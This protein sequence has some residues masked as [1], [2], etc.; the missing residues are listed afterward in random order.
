MK[1]TAVLITALI[2]LLV[3][4]GYFLY[5]FWYK[6]PPIDIWQAIPSSAIMV[7]ENSNVVKTWNELQVKPVW[8]S[9]Q[10]IPYYQQL[11]LNIANLDSIPGE[12]GAL[13]RVLRDQ[14]FLCSLHMISKEAFDFLFYVKV[15][16]LR[17]QE[18]LSQIEDHYRS[19]NKFQFLQRNYQ[20]FTINEFKKRGEDQFFSYIIH[21]NYFMASFSPFLVEGV[22]RNL[23]DKR[24]TSFKDLNPAL[25]RLKK[26]EN[27][28]GNLYVN[29][30]QLPQFFSVFSP[31]KDRIDLEPLKHLAQSILFDLEVNEEGLRC[32]GF[33]LTESVKGQ[34]LESFLGQKPQEMRLKRLLSNRTALLYHFSYQEPE[35]WLEV[36][37]NYWKTNQPNQIQNKATLQENYGFQTD[38]LGSWLGNELG[39]AVLESINPSQPDRLIY[40]K[41]ADPNQALNQFNRLAEESAALS[42]DSLYKEPYAGL[43]IREIK[44]TEFPAKLLGGLFSGFGQC[45]VMLFDDYIILGSNIQTLKNL[46]RDI[47]REDVWSKSP[48]KNTFFESTLKE[49]NLSVIVDMNRFWSL[50]EVQTTPKWMGFMQSYRTQLKRFDLAAL[51]FSDV[52]DKFYTNLVLNHQNLS[53]ATKPSN[54]YQFVQKVPVQTP[55]IT[56][57]FVVRNHANNAREV[58]VQDQ[59]HF[60]YLIS[61]EGRLLWRDSLPGPIRGKVNQIDYFKNGKLQYLLATDRDLHL[62]DRTGQQVSGFPVTVPTEA[63]LRNV[64]PIDYDNSKNYRLIAS[65][66][67]GNIYLFDKEGGLLEGW[68]PRTLKYQLVSAPVHL[69]VRGKDCI[70]AVQENGLI[71]ILNRRGKLYPGFPVDVKGDINSPLFIEIGTDFDNTYFTAITQNGELVRFNLNGSILDKKQF[72]KPTRETLFGLSSDALSKDYVIY[73]QTGN[74]LGILD[75]DENLILEKDYLTPG[76]LQI[77]YYYFSSGNKVFAVT[78]S[79]QQ[80]TYL[81][82]QD[83]K[84]INDQPIESSQEIGLIYFEKLDKYQV[85]SIYAQQFSLRSFNK[86]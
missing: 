44:V 10:Q 82:D 83:G 65:D 56:K 79:E 25:T 2:V 58:L 49:A 69:R 59:E 30:Q 45:F 16:R 28:D 61:S 63:M 66:G 32:S 1:K 13:D 64:A 41:A 81:Y 34:F 73:R 72:Y 24:R 17:D 11:N 15:G 5:E 78:D 37:N 52:G 47:E 22:I 38:N 23:K 50:L 8:V 85:Y 54:R 48:T 35:K 60:L 74:R 12:V 77:Q 40:L 26:L 46:I 31:E 75:R 62:I 67:I 55:L 6:K 33:T 51:Q 3:V 76:K 21:E 84:L 19:D 7:Y 27:D 80:F 42:G 57:P 29:A 70:V 4:G 68:N 71:N 20:D 43:E 36:I 14:N 18:I 9:L 53:I 86:E 39:L